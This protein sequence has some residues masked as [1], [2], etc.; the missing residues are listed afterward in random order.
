MP[1]LGS[2]QIVDPR[3]VWKNEEKDF[4]PWVA[5]NISELSK[6]IGIPLVAETTEKRVGA[7]EL[8]ILARVEGSDKIVIIENQ[9]EET[10]HKHLGQLITYASGLDAAIVVWVAPYITE[11]HK[12]SIDWLNR[13]S[14]SD[15]S[16]YLVRPEVLRIDSS[17]PATRFYLEAGPS[18][19]TQTISGIVEE[20]EGPIHVFR[21]VFWSS[22]LS[23]LISRGHPWASNRKTSKQAYITFPIGKSGI[24]VNVSM[25]M[26]SRIRVEIFIYSDPEK[27]I[28][29]SLIPKKNEI[30]ALFPDETVSWERLDD[31]A[32]S[33]VAVYRPY[34]RDEVS[35][36]SPA[37]TALYEWIE[38]NLVRFRE[39]SQKF[40]LK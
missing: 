25:A 12:D 6:A 2:L 8:D 35:R 32:A 38:K 23:F 20:E 30:D 14:K 13:I 10:D 24:G 29:D 11:E 15:V 19:F 1:D 3:E 39:V 33:R 36:E 27:I 7:Y 17:K 34:D 26:G 40:L 9:L 4:T 18:E 16:F 22:L 5:K 21:R 37:R 31:G 28:F